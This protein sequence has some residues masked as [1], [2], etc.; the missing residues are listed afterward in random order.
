M[1]A[2]RLLLA[3]VAL[4]HA[5]AA[6]LMMPNL[7]VPMMEDALVFDLFLAAPLSLD[8]ERFLAA[9]LAA[10]CPRHFGPS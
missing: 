9:A 5:A 8:Q 4:I 10:S 7:L 3:L 6:M 2:L 1:A